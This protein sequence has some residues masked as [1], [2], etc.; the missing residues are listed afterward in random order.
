MP[1]H[2]VSLDVQRL[3]VRRDH[4][5]NDGLPIRTFGPKLLGHEVHGLKHRNQTDAKNRLVMRHTVAR[6]IKRLQ[7]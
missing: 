4:F 7:M 2:T 3:P 1:H 5:S 6:L